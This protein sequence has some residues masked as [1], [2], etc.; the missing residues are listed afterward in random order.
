MFRGAV[1]YLTTPGIVY[2]DTKEDQCM[3]HWIKELGDSDETPYNEPS[4]G[5]S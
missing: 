5:L 4:G 1:V 2:E 3:G